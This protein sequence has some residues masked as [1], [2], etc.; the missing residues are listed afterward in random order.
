MRWSGILYAVGL[1][2]AVN[3]IRTRD[4][5]YFRSAEE[6]AAFIEKYKPKVQGQRGGYKGLP[7]R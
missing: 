3:A 4:F 2:A 7:V 1:L 6:R 5:P